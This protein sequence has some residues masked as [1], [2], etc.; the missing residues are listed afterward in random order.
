MAKYYVCMTLITKASDSVDGKNHRRTLY[1]AGTAD[2]IFGDM[3]QYDVK[4]KA[5]TFNS[6]KEANRV[7]KLTHGWVKKI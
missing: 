7:A 1:F 4:K 6:R 5:R 3:Y 2:S